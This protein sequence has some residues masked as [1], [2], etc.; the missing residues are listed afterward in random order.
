MVEDNS[1]T[2]FKRRTVKNRT[3]EGDVDRMEE[4]SEMRS[5]PGRTGAITTR[6][7]S[8]CHTPE[9]RKYKKTKMQ[10]LPMTRST[11]E[12][13]RRDAVTIL[14]RLGISH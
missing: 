3:S 6:G 7:V 14:P 2:E 1:P 8:V 5:I 10:G 13:G 4:N 11:I 9:P 12:G